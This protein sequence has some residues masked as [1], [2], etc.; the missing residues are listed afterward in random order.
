LAAHVDE[1]RVA[2]AISRSAVGPGAESLPVGGVAVLDAD[3]N[4]VHQVV[5]EPLKP[6]F[7]RAFVWES[8]GLHDD[9][10]TLGLGDGRVWREGGGR[11]LS[12]P[13]LAGDVPISATIGHLVD[14]GD[15]VFA[16]TSGTSI[17][18][19]S[20]RPE[21]QPPQAHPME[22]ALVAL[23]PATLETQWTWRGEERVQGLTVRDRWVVVGVAPRDANADRHGV[24]VL[25]KQLDGSGA[26]RVAASCSTGQP[27]FF[28]TAIAPDGRL[29]VVSF[30]EKVD[31]VVRGDY[32]V[33]L[34][35]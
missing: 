26:K 11:S 4:L 18:Y 35:L 9:R 12:T 17:P 5:P 3:L 21:T 34:F 29:A 7:D 28:R 19:G 30:P 33:T 13:I 16:L 6:W 8:I 2:I 32:R 23:D 24:I 14:D 25:D 31:D 15:T 10:L 27:V 1:D 20:G 22:N